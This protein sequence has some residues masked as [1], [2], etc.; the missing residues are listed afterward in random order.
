MRAPA[1]GRLLSLCRGLPLSL[2]RQ[3]SGTAATRVSQR[4]ATLLKE[5]GTPLGRP[6]RPKQ[7]RAGPES[8]DGSFI[9]GLKAG[10]TGDRSTHVAAGTP[11]APRPRDAPRRVA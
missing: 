2:P 7:H 10:A 9:H 3:P 4:D 11:R 1:A 5:P 6:A 8:P